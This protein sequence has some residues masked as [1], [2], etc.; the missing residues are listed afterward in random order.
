MVCYLTTN[1]F[2]YLERDVPYFDEICAEVATLYLNRTITP[3]A[4]T[5]N[6]KF[7]T[8]RMRSTFIYYMCRIS[9]TINNDI[10][11]GESL[12]E[13]LLIGNILASVQGNKLVRLYG[14]SID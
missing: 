5:R 7:S 10:F 13:R 12:V 8:G 4:Y 1:C 9:L 3:G 2:Q 6:G 11:T 14:N